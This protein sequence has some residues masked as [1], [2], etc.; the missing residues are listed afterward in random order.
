LSFN[1]QT[2]PANKGQVDYIIGLQIPVS[3]TES[4]L[5]NR[6]SSKF[7][8]QSQSFSFLFNEKVNKI[9]FGQ[10]QTYLT[11][12]LLTF[13]VFHTAAAGSSVPTNKWTLQ[14]SSTYLSKQNVALTVDGNTYVAQFDS[15]SAFITVDAD[16]YNKI[17]TG[18]NIVVDAASSLVTSDC[19]SNL[20]SQDDALVF[21]FAN[22]ADAKFNR[23]SVKTRDL[24]IKQEDGKCVFL[25]QKG[26]APA[27]RSLVTWTLGTTFLKNVYTYFDYTNY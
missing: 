9:F 1:G 14:V 4:Y 22:N 7:R 25:L 2:S 19:T 5:S 17:Y 26:P 15:T 11:D 24:F 23:F 16:T 6:I 27:A 18:L 12:K 13:P 3:E 8:V 10:P 21:V 20:N